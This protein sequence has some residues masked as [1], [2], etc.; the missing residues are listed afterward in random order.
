ML[1][2]GDYSFHMRGV[3]EWQS[4]GLCRTKE[5]LF[6][7]K[8]KEAK[9]LCR[10]CPVASECLHYAIIYRER[11]IWG[12]TSD[13]ERHM[14]IMKSPELRNQLIREAIQQGLYEVR[15]SIAQYIDSIHSARQLRSRTVVA[16]PP[17]PEQVLEEFAE[18][19]AGW[20]SLLES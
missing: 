10:D 9:K 20:Y 3:E 19:S 16:P 12:A 14:I 7:K 2:R 5:E 6:D 17:A 11:G 1:P 15:F 8:P 4:E 13:A 18:L